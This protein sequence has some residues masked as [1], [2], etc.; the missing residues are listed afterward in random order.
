MAE[1][2]K[3]IYKIC[4]EQAGYTQEQAAEMLNVSLRVLCRY[5]SGE[6]QVPN[7]VV[8]GM[9]SLYND[10]YVAVSHVLNSFPPTV[11]IIPTP[12]LCDIQTGS[13]RV[14]NRV[15]AFLR[16]RPDHRLLAIAEDGIID[17]SEVQ[18]LDD[19]LD[20]L[21]ALVKVFTELR[22]AAERGRR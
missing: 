22:L 13:M 5:E 3:T 20:D 11:H 15:E 14:F 7:D 1:T 8:A 19:I 2:G 6:I 17:E 21:E 18:D 16:K 12:E 9:V 4:R 10:N